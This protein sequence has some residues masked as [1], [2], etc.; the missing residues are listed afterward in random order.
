MNEKI[1][2]PLGAVMYK[3]RSE[4]KCFNYFGLKMGRQGLTVVGPN[5]GKNKGGWG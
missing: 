1:K 2:L 5:V 3:S 4:I